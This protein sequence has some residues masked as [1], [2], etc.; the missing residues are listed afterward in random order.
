MLSVCQGAC[1]DQMT[2]EDLDIVCAEWIKRGDCIRNPQKMMVTCA[3]S[4]QDQNIPVHV[5]EDSMCKVRATEGCRNS[6]QYMLLNCE[7]TCYNQAPPHHLRDLD[8]RCSKRVDLKSLCRDRGKAIGF[9]FSVREKS[10]TDLIE[11]SF[12]I[13]AKERADRGECS[14]SDMIIDFPTLCY[15]PTLPNP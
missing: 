15:N 8:P 13:K 12:P 7:I 10:C 6:P 1:L 3:P 11:S 2:S 14:Q 9:F 5:D 4:C